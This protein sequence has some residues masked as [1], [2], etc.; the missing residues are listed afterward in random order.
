MRR[1]ISLAAL[2]VI[3]SFLAGCGETVN[4]VVKD[5]R[6]IGKGVRKVFVR[7]GS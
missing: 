7:E 5:T 6:R 3:V 1:L 4:G 2:L